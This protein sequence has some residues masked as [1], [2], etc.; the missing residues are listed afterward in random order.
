MADVYGDKAA[1]RRRRRRPHRQQS[2][3]VPGHKKS[4][5][6]AVLLLSAIC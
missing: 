3:Q 4:T 6:Q 2:R 5:A 1:S